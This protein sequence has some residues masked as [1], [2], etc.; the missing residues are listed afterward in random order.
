MK[1]IFCIGSDRIPRYTLIK[2]LGM[3]RHSPLFLMIC[4]LLLNVTLLFTI[5]HKIPHSPWLAHPLFP[6]FPS[7]QVVE[8]LHSYS[9]WTKYKSLINC[10]TTSGHGHIIYISLTVAL[11][12]NQ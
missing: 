7:G 3:L 11:E 9:S 4:H 6:H 10:L 12:I 1:R 5:K 8:I 2:L